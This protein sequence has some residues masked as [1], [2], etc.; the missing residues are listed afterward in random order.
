[1]NLKVKNVALHQLAPVG[2]REIPWLPLPAVLALKRRRVRAR[3]R[4]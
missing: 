3:G 2:V 1:M 4:A